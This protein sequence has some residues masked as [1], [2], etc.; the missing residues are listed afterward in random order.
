[1]T[2]GH[3]L[4]NLLTDSRLAPVAPTPPP[5]GEKLSESR[6]ADVRTLCTTLLNAYLISLL[7]TGLLHA[8]V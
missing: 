2:L 7:D 5:A 4:A 8:G 6:A 1:M 3:A